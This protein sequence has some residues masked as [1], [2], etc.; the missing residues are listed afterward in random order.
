MGDVQIFFVRFSS[1]LVSKLPKLIDFV[2][3]HEISTKV[4]EEFQAISKVITILN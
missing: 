2:E 1:L 4:R 3:A